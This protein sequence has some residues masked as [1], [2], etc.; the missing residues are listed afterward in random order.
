MRG[1]FFQYRYAYARSADS[2]DAD[3]PGQDYL[4]YCDLEQSFV[5][6]ACD[7]VGSSF[8]GDL[9]ARFL[10]DELVRWLR[11][12][13]AALSDAR[14]FKGSLTHHL[15][16]VLLGDA[17]R[18][19]D[20]HQFSVDVDMLSEY[21]ESLR[22]KGSETMFV[23][24]RLDRPGPGLPDGR[25][26]LAWLGDMRLA[27]WRASGRVDL[28]G[29]FDTSRR[30]ST[31][32]GLVGGPL[33]VYVASLTN[34]DNPVMRL[35]AYSDGLDVFDDLLDAELPDEKL[36]EIVTS[37]RSQSGSDD[38]SFL[39]LWAGASAPFAQVAPVLSVAVAETVRSAPPP[40]VPVK[41]PSKPPPVNSVS[42]PLRWQPLLLV[43]VL[44]LL[45]GLTAGN[46]LFANGSA[47]EPPTGIGRT[48][49]ANAVA[50]SGLAST[51]T[52]TPTKTLAPTASPPAPTDTATLTP[53]QTP[54]HTPTPTAAAS[55]TVSPFMAAA[56][57]VVDTD[58][59]GLS[60]D[61]DMCPFDDGSAYFDGGGYGCKSFDLDADG[62]IDVV[63]ECKL[64]HKGSM[65]DPARRGC[66]LSVSP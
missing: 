55:A 32:R 23:C 11:E 51:F 45:L 35:V 33:S 36:Q 13:E 41:T 7:G 1:P 47:P 4:V 17:T 62:V 10:G 19:I 50:F 16:S 2:T 20:A 44:G 3:E 37:T 42:S 25:I 49:T 29:A 64:K 9:G 14:T 65:P 58:G 15:S 56:V 18:M 24:G 63:D 31:K 30:W 12:Q 46:L 40:P 8:F 59:D 66:P 6:A 60:D 27:L 21:L 52:P 5:F 39:E 43:G 48:P 53:T 38:V 57:T 22:N 26:A 61:L 54:T 34:P 28:G